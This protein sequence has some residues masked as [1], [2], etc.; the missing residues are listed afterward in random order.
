M[1]EHLLERA[2]TG[3][4]RCKLC[5]EP[6]EKGALRI[7]VTADSTSFD[8]TMKIWHHG[9]CA[10]IRRPHPFLAAL[11]NFMAVI[12]AE[13]EQLTAIANATKSG[14][15]KQVVWRHA[16]EPRCVLEFA[17]EK[18]MLVTSPGKWLVWGPLVVASVP[19]EDLQ[20]VVDTAT[21]SG[22]AGARA[23]PQSRNQNRRARAERPPR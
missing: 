12:G 11:R 23:S 5:K 8:G 19:D 6:I 7:G 4:S 21:A 15:L 17:A 2:S 3:R 14:K 22:V 10:A 18:Y 16:T 13:R 20:D 9:I 1:S